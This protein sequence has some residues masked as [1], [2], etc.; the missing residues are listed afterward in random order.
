MAEVTIEIEVDSQGAI[1]GVRNLEGS[2]NQSLGR[3][4]SSGD[5]AGTGVSGLDK[6]LQRLTSSRAPNFLGAVN[7]QLISQIP[8]FRNNAAAAS[9]FGTAAFSLTQ[10]LNKLIGPAG[11]IILGVGALSAFAVAAFNSAKSSEQL[12]GSLSD[13]SQQYLKLKELGLTAIGTQEELEK[14]T[15]AVK[16]R[17]ALLTSELEGT[18]S[19]LKD[20]KLWIDAQ[21][22]ALRKLDEALGLVKNK[23]ELRLEIEK[24][25]GVLKSSQDMLNKWDTDKVQEDIKRLEDPFIALGKSWALETFGLVNLF[26]TT[27]EHFAS[28][29]AKL[30]SEITTLKDFMGGSDAE[31]FEELKIKSL[32]D[33]EAILTKLKQVQ[34]HRIVLPVET[35]RPIKLP[36]DEPDEQ[37]KQIQALA[38]EY[39]ETWTE[40]GFT[41]NDAMLQAARERAQANLEHIEQT[42]QAFLSLTQPIKQAFV[43]AFMG[44]E[45]NWQQMLQRMLADLAISG[46]FEAVADLFGF[47]KEDE[48]LLE[49][50]LPFQKGTPYVPRTGL[51]LLHQG[52]AVIP[53]EKNIF[54][55]SVTNQSFGGNTI[56][57][58]FYTQSIDRNTLVKWIR[59]ASDRREFDI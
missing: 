40:A 51:A 53:A 48:S 30:I 46:L 36:W 55:R 32:E 38:N 45:V 25:T 10:T 34:S 28:V 5:K 59:Q 24:L 22:P 50:I 11:L 9:L 47:G 39:V 18:I 43:D 52:E 16:L 19:P 17:I 8:L 49:K 33:L 44:V 13:L 23:Q 15:E 41:V 3:I 31:I 57:N 2:L 1:A 6:N 58:N 42:R 12:A 54:N 26:E 7:Q 29:R 35:V 27:E 21:V 4:A 20:Y 56:I 14:A 37:E